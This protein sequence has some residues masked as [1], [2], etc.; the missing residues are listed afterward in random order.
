MVERY[1]KVL[2][3]EKPELELLRQVK[4]WP[5]QLYY[6]GNWDPGLF[7]KCAAV[8]GSRRM[9]TYG[10]RVVEM[11]V[12]KLVDAGFTIVSGFMYGVDMA[13]HRMAIECG[14]KTIAVLGWGIKNRSSGY[15]DDKTLGMIVDGGGLV[16]SEWE[17]QLGQLWTFP[18]R[19]RIV[20]G[21]CGELYIVE[22]AGHSGALITA[23]LALKYGRQVWAVPGP[24]TSGVSVGTNKWIEEG[25]A[26]P[27]TPGMLLAMG[28]I[29]CTKEETEVLSVLQNDIFS[30]D[31]LVRKM[32]K[33][34]GQLGALLMK[35]ELK[36]VIEEREG[37]YW[38]KEKNK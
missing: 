34:T 23:E 27:W 32:G 21:L 2:V 8:V 15:Q 35:M 31:E 22:A 29:Q 1:K 6:K 36:G 28:D 19:N 18:Q 11:L 16:L 24:V 5:K 33:E 20:A 10:A 9:T 13:A 17:E 14:G 30:L 25:K 12:P 26:R 4:N 3:G 38:V 37:K 7:A